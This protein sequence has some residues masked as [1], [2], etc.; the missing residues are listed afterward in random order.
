MSP[1]L[2]AQPSLPELSEQIWLFPQFR[3]VIY[4]L[5]NLQLVGLCD[6]CLYKVNNILNTHEAKLT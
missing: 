5:D 6:S 3:S 1:E 2:S 4:H